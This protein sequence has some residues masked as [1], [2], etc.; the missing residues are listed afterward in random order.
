MNQLLS[1]IVVQA[2][3]DLDNEEFESDAVDFFQSSWFELLVEELHLN[4]ISIKKQV[5]NRTYE[6]VNIR[7]GYR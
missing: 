4:P 6:R 5:L 1:A 2:V 7:A 3:K